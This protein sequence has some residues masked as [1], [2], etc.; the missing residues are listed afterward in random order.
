ML[1]LLFIGV[2]MMQH[3]SGKEDQM[4]SSRVQEDTLKSWGLRKQEG[5]FPQ[6][7]PGAPELLS[8][9]GGF[10]IG[11][12]DKKVLYLT[13][14]QGYEN[15]YTP[16]ILD[17]LKLHKVQAV[18]FITGH[19]LLQNEALVKRMLDEG[20]EVGNHGMLHKSL[21]SLNEEELKKELQDLD[22][23]FF[24]RFKRRMKWLRPAKGEYS[25][26]SLR[27]S[28]EMGYTNVFWS[29]A[30]QD[31]LAEKV[32]GEEYAFHQ[33]SRY[34]HNGS[35]ILLHAVSPDN[36]YALDRIIRDAKERGYVFGRMEE[37]IKR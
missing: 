10:Y 21:P 9:Y 30:Y 15:G 7:D 19:Y 31:W 27:L 8:K 11:N 32:R 6:A 26:K 25:E 13:F 24:E 20:H 16:K 12:T 1:L 22:D 18:F 36:A 28:T 3:Y 5:G 34:L 14:D 29:F 35:I 2:N 4:V 37:L 17:V 23:A 33:V